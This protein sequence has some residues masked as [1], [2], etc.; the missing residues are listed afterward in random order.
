MEGGVL[1]LF[2]QV[3]L[4]LLL[5]FLHWFSAGG[6]F[7]SM[8]MIISGVLGSPWSVPL[9][10][11]GGGE[12]VGR[13]ITFQTELKSK[14]MTLSWGTAELGPSPS[15]LFEL[16]FPLELSTVPVWLT[17]GGSWEEHQK[18]SEEGLPK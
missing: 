18:M 5:L 3:V 13:S 12:E 16:L 14:V 6:L 10:T 9:E 2:L 17:I 8:E 1:L 7:R 4:L 11:G 15:V